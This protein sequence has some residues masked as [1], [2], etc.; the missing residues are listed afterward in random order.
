MLATIDTLEKDSKHVKPLNESDEEE[1]EQR[2]KA[3]EVL[4]RL[5]DVS[6]IHQYSNHS[7]AEH[8]WLQAPDDRREEARG[9]ELLLSAT[10]LHVYCTE[11]DETD[12]E[13]LEVRLSVS[14]RRCRHSFK[15]Y[16][17]S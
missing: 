9:V 12:L 13:P 17:A 14:A 7:V 3:R 11:D 2:R 10:L 16:R 1:V 5:K 6:C 15:V 8:A 4:A